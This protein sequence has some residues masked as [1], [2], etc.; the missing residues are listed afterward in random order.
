MW[1]IKLKA[2]K[3]Q[4][5]NLIV[6]YFV[7]GF[8]IKGICE[9]YNSLRKCKN[10]HLSIQSAFSFPEV[11]SYLIIL[12]I[13]TV[14]VP[15]GNATPHRLSCHASLWNQGGDSWHSKVG[16]PQTGTTS[17]H[18]VVGLVVEN[19]KRR[20]WKLFCIQ[21]NFWTL[22]QKH[23][24][25][26]QTKILLSLMFQSMS[27]KVSIR[28]ASIVME[29]LRRYDHLLC[30]ICPVFEPQLQLPYEI[31]SYIKVSLLIW[32]NSKTFSSEISI[33]WHKKKI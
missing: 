31:W 27:E 4:L 15:S 16:I 8:W 20:P 2:L 21:G 9:K 11:S 5:F 28:Q 32:N 26:G 13:I 18:I 22:I 17:V 19:L 6:N 10:N 25:S 3:H 24:K 1:N 12:F 7:I 33:S 29:T 23:H 14:C 30:M